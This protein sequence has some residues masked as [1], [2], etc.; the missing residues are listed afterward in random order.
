[1]KSVLRPTTPDDLS[2][3]SEFLQRVFGA[4]ANAPFTQS[5]VMHWKYWNARGDW[6][7]PRAYVLERDGA[8]TAHAGLWPLVV[9]GVR[10]VHMIDWA[11]APEAPGAGLLMVQKLA[12]M[13]DFIIAI[14]GSDMTRA[15]LPAYGFAEH[16]QQWTGARPIHPLR[17]ILTH[18]HKNWKLIPRLGRNMMW[19]SGSSA[20]TGWI[21]EEIAPERVD[22]PARLAPRSAE[23]F[24]YLLACP[25]AGVHF[26]QV[27][28]GGKAR[29][30]FVLSAI[31]GQARLAGLWLY[32][33]NPPS[34]RAAYLLAQAEARKLADANEFTAAGSGTVTEQGA[35][36]SGLHLLGEM[37]PVFLLNKKKNLALPP[38]FQFQL[39][40]YDGF[41]LD[42]GGYCYL[43]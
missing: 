6:P 35:R 3:V 10:G 41:F 33:T 38:D 25:I 12:A 15:I 1:M 11:S 20:P 43:T 22:D 7:E 14:G 23:F 32:E 26:Y 9:N 24:R 42:A 5:A 13:F 19:S 40:E 2:A 28:E 39:V 30:H 17:Q 37:T 8:I 18:Q 21:A 4:A 31:R 36:E 29:G 16:A 27:R 34:A